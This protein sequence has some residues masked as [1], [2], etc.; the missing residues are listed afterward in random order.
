VVAKLIRARPEQQIWANSFEGD[1]ADAL[2]IQA[3]IAGTIA[4]AVAVELTPEAEERLVQAQTRVVDPRAMEAY[5]RARE[6]SDATISRAG[7]ETALRHY[8]EAITLDP[9]F[10]I[11]YAG[12]A[13]LYTQASL[14]TVVSPHESLAYAKL[15]AQKALELDPRSAE[16]LLAK[17]TV[18]F[19]FDWDWE[20][21]ARDFRQAIDLNPNA[22][23]YLH[24]YALYLVH[25]GFFD[26]AIEHFKRAEELTPGE[27][28]SLVTIGWANLYANR[29]EPV[30]SMALECLDNDPENPIPFFHL[31]WAHSLL[32]QYDDATAF[33]DSLGANYSKL[34]LAD[35]YSVMFWMRGKVYAEAGQREKALEMIESLED[36]AN[37]HFI[38]PWYVAQIHERLGNL[39]EAFT[40]LEEAFE[41]R[42]TSLIDLRL[43]MGHLADDPRY[44]D[45]ARRVG[46]PLD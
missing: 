45:L 46:I 39:D 31:A 38:D 13:C 24:A 5:L 8:Q 3:Q 21:P 42:S 17:A 2:A 40:L 6:V 25:R 27:D 22:P 33:A 30:I 26:E 36:L 18:G 4:G 32:G 29:P 44:Q 28:Y 9:E 23:E 43:D 11:A 12:L 34:G 1:F 10:G 7:F 19:Y 14:F 20:G 41:M 37:E 16:A 35:L 15:T